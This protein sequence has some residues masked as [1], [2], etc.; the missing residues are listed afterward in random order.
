MDNIKTFVIR[1]TVQLISCEDSY[2]YWSDFRNEF[3]SWGKHDEFV[4]HRSANRKI[5][6]IG[7]GQ[8]V[9]IV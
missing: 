9:E 6:E 1:Q 8:A 3:V 5:K 4:T 7:F 2:A